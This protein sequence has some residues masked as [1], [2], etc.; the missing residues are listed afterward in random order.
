MTLFKKAIRLCFRSPPSHIT[1][2]HQL[3]IFDLNECSAEQ[4]L[5]FS[6][7]PLLLRKPSLE[8]TRHVSIQF[9]FPCPSLF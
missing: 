6:V 1:N 4:M 9:H 7:M 2:K 3:F 8:N 5:Q